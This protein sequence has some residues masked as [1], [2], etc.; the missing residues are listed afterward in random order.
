[1]AR[2]GVQM[3]RVMLVLLAGSI[4]LAQDFK[5][6]AGSKLDEKAT[7]EASATAPGKVSEVY[8]TSD[9]FDK[10]YAFYK[11]LYK[12]FAMPRQPPKQPSGQ[13]IKWAFFILDG[14]TNLSNSK[15]W[16]KIQRPYIGGVDGSD[17][18]DITVIQTIRSK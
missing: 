9:S 1:M 17:T 4:L 5:P 15:Y 8:T 3:R 14:G 2:G 10:V 18:R 16:M 6:Y 13:Q 12:E 7:R 11:A